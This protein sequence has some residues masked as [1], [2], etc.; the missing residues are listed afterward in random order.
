MITSVSKLQFKLYS[1]PTM[2]NKKLFL[3]ALFLVLLK[4]FNSC[5]KKEAVACDKITLSPKVTVSPYKR[6]YRVGDTLLISWIFFLKEK[7]I[8]SNDSILLPKT[9]NITSSFGLIEYLPQPI[10]F[11]NAVDNFKYKILK[12]V[13]EFNMLV[14]DPNTERLHFRPILYTDSYNFSFLLIPNKKGVYGIGTSNNNFWMTKTCTADFIPE[15]VSGNSNT[16]LR[17]STTNF[18]LWSDAN[19]SSFYFEVR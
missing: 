17:D 10:L 7:N 11:R 3:A 1:P 5:T 12:G 4:I 14:N 9:L 18:T 2:F 13:G 8:I 6:V 16:F 19:Q 15:F